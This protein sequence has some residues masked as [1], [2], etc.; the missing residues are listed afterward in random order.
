MNFEAERRVRV[1]EVTDLTTI[2]D[3]LPLH[4]QVRRRMR[5]VC[6]LSEKHKYLRNLLLVHNLAHM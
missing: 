4:F 6:A 3:S 5:E 1:D 2:M